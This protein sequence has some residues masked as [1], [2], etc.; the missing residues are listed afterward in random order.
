MADAQQIVNRFLGIERTQHAQQTHQRQ[1]DFCPCSRHLDGLG[2][3]YFCA[4]YGVEPASLEQQQRRSFECPRRRRICLRG[5]R[6][7]LPLLADSRPC[8]RNTTPNHAAEHRHAAKAGAADRSPL[9]CHSSQSDLPD[10]AATT[11]G[12]RVLTQAA[13]RPKTPL[14]WLC[15]R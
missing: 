5:M 11:P 4:V 2:R 9:S 10:R 12:I 1:G 7:S 14:I 6:G 13:V 8:A 15:T 3:A